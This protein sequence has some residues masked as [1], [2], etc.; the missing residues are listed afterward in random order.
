MSAAP[1]ILRLLTVEIRTEQDVVVA[2][3]RARQLAGKIGFEGQVQTRIATAVSEIARNAYQ[4]AG[5]GVAEYSVADDPQPSN[6]RRARHTLTIEVRDRG[7]GIARLDEVLGGHYRSESGLGIGIVGTQRL[8]DRVQIASTSQGTTVT[9]S[10]VLPPA[11]FPQSAAQLQ[12]FAAS[13]DAEN[14]ANPLH[15]IRVQNQELIRTMD[16]ARA[17]QEE[18]V[19]VN[20]ELAETNTGVLAL[21]DELE[22]LNRV[23]AMLASKLELKPLIQSIIE[24]T[25]ALT[26]AELGAFFFREEDDR[27]AL[28][29]TAGARSDALPESLSPDTVAAFFAP[30]F[31]VSGF[32][33]ASDLEAPEPD[34]GGAA[35]AR[36]VAGRLAVRS[37]LT[38]A[39]S[40]AS[41]RLMGALLFAAGRPQAFTERS[42]RILSS[43][44]TQAAV[45]IEKAQLFQTV[46]AASDAKDRFFATLSHELRTPLNPALAV[47][48]SLENDARV[49]ADL[50]EDIS[51]VARNI[52]LEARLIDDLLDFNRL[53][54]GKLELVLDT[55]DLHA[56][57]ESVIAICRHDLEEKGHRLER[58]FQSPRSSVLGDAGRLQQVFWNVL[59]NA[60]KFT[61]PGGIIRI[62]TEP[63]GENLRARITDTGRGI[64]PESIERIFSD[65]D[66]GQME[67]AAHFGGLGLGLAIARMFVQLHHGTITAASPGVGLGATITIELPLCDA[68][69]CRPAATETAPAPAPKGHVRILL[70]DDHADT[71][72]GLTRLLERRGFAV[73][74]ASTGAQA[75]HEAGQQSFHL[76]ISD[77]GL[78]DITGT[79]LVRQIHAIQTLPAIALSGY[80]MEADRASSK[81]AGFSTHITKPVDF[82]QLI[83]A[84]HT[85]PE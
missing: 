67:N 14:P 40:D 15:E 52:R 19:R 55:L 2:R 68:P 54:K 70:V 66:Q 81:E 4:Y 62:H 24:V 72:R 5:G 44:A 28:Y 34:S 82:E 71:L 33:H 31:A 63:A 7:P 50:R 32:V 13:L 74:P 29:A 60:I 73:T 65:F 25:T 39:V 85:L 20:Q 42:E 30:G 18:L 78:P 26:D 84:I 35:F 38:V 6:P 69:E 59:K 22:T 8:M 16:E 23:S 17:R 11:V 48:S 3:Q 77:L 61:P 1:T 27:W 76:L 21:Y 10:K 56:L 41:G 9:L 53:I 36:A 80:G 64:E 79:E 58:D 47:I 12:A 43:V 49:P 57:I 51:I 46:T 83:T 75:L 45:G 37:C